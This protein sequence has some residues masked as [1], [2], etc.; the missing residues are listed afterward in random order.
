MAYNTL[1]FNGEACCKIVVLLLVVGQVLYLSLCTVLYIIQ[2]SMITVSLFQ[3]QQN[4]VPAT[5]S[6]KTDF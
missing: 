2:T 5:V 1:V 4:S 3:H 6:L